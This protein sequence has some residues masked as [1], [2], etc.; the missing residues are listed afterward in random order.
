MFFSRTKADWRFCSLIIVE[1]L[2]RSN[3]WTVE[4]S[5]VGDRRA[6]NARLTKSVSRFV[7]FDHI[8]YLSPLLIHG[9]II[10]QE[11]ITFRKS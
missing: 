5:T 10:W 7:S 6:K 3:E 4:K 1:I 11:K 9:I 2:K 8:F